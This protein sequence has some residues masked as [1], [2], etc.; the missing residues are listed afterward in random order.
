MKKKLLAALSN[1]IGDEDGY[2]EM[3]MISHDEITPKNIHIFL[4]D[5]SEDTSLFSILREMYLQDPKNFNKKIKK[6]A[7]VSLKNKILSDNVSYEFVET[8]ALVS[9]I[10][11]I[12]KLMK[13]QQSP[14]KKILTMYFYKRIKKNMEKSPKKKAALLS[15]YRRTA[16]TTSSYI[17]KFIMSNAIEEAYFL[18]YSKDILWELKNSF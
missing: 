10:K 1:S 16:N 13:E 11:W 8:A 17:E 5:F 15:E 12:R 4:A 3:R 6:I 14:S 7:K 9:S 2:F 18:E